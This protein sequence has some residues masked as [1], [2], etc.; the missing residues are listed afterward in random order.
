MYGGLEEPASEDSSYEDFS[1]AVNIHMPQSCGSTP[2]RTH[3]MP[4]M[5]PGGPSVEQCASAGPSLSLPKIPP[6]EGKESLSD[7]SLRVVAALEAMELCRCH[8][9]AERELMLQWRTS[10]S[11][12]VFT[13]WRWVW[14][15]PLSSRFGSDPS[16][17]LR[18]ARGY[19]Q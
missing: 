15:S 10:V 16:N 11:R 18:P 9:H 2:S 13:W 19:D 12:G 1:S 7:G 4:P 5:A 17:F 8:R 3:C 6:L 14:L